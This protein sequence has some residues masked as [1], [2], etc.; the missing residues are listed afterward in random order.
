MSPLCCVWCLACAM[1]LVHPG[2]SQG[3]EGMSEVIGECFESS[4]RHDPVIVECLKCSVWHDS[5]VVA[6]LSLGSGM[7]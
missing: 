4:I 2:M 7:C 6:Y 3:M 5:V 1:I